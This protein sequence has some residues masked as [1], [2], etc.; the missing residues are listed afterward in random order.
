MIKKL[1]FL[2]MVLSFVSVQAASMNCALN[3]S[4]IIKKV[5]QKMPAGHECC[6]S[7]KEKK[8]E[9]EKSNCLGEM[10][11]S[12]YLEAASTNVSQN[13]EEVKATQKIINLQH[14]PIHTLIKK[15]GINNRYKPK[16]PDQEYLAFKARL[17]LYLLKDQFLN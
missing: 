15:V 4:M 8:E 5:E 11:G 1:M 3:C 9:K 16:I 12:C 14:L 6:H 10:S 7:N 17:D 2:L 13:F